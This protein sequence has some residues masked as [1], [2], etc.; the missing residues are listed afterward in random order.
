[1]RKLILQCGLA[2]GD[3]VMLTA[4][5]R[6]MHHHY[7]G[8][9]L[10]DVRTSCPEI[11]ENNPHI[12]PLEDGD[13]E[14]ER[15]ECS[16]SLIDQADRVPY[17][18]LHGFIDFFNERFR[19]SIRPTAFRGDI[20]LS[21]QDK[22][23]YSQVREVTRRDIPFWI[24]AAGGKFDITIKWWESRRYQEVVHRLAG[25][26][27]FVQ[28]GELGHHHP[29]LDG[30][31]DLR[32]QTNLRELIR[33]VYHSE[34]VVCPTTALMHLAAAVESKHGWTRRRPCVVIAGGREPTHW[35]QYPGHHYLHTIGALPCCANGGC[36][37]DRT[38]RLRDGE[39]QDKPENLCA[40]VVGKLPK[41]LDLITA[42]DVVRRIESYFSGGA[43]AY[44]TSSQ[45]KAAK[46]GIAATQRNRYDDQPLNL[47]SAG[48]AFDEAAG[49]AIGPVDGEGKG[50]VI[51][52]GGVRYFTNAWVCINM[53]RRLGCQLPVEVWHLGKREMTEKMRRLLAKLNV[54]TIDAFQVRRRKPARRLNGWELKV[55]AIIHSRFREVLFLDADNVPVANPEFLFDCEEFRSA[56]AI[57]WP[58]FKQTH[59]NDDLEIWRS[60]GL[61][62]PSEPEFESGQI[63][64]D[65]AR[66]SRALQLCLWLNEHSDFYYRH[67]YG[68]KE[69][70]HLAFQK[71]HKSYHLIKHPVLA[72]DRTMCQHDPQG[73][74]LFQ[75]RNFAK[76]DLVRNPHI[77]GFWMESECLGYLAELKKDWDGGVSDYSPP[78]PPARWPRTEPRLI[79]AISAAT[80]EEAE[81]TQANLAATDWHTVP[82]ASWVAPETARLRWLLENA[83]D[84]PADYILL[85]EGELV[86]NRHIRH[87]LLRWQPIRRRQAGVASVYNPQIQ[88][89]ACDF[90]NNTRLVSK[91]DKL[92]NEA[93]V[94]SAAAARIILEG[95]KRTRVSGYPTVPKVAARLGQPVMLH[96]PSLVQRAFKGPNGDISM[97]FDFDPQWRAV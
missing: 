87:N 76:W 28:V 21:A 40:N 14:A 50:I 15:V 35:E 57:F 79:S 54:R 71:A 30:V 27:Q 61:R 97:A 6:D 49:L 66:C 59:Q 89:N 29:R 53:L 12:T 62:R 92:G 74:R 25:K 22:A 3:I 56:G 8:H 44:L 41:C 60:C 82:V 86:F 93:I 46:R 20:H 55:Y 36:W 11:W 63:L 17:H 32:G 78:R 52:A 84:H 4:A 26:V 94:L 95:L 88:E 10:T 81:Q 7:P 5:V 96:A 38:F 75:H 47:S 69:T 72:L 43:L 19:L 68:D 13:P 85:L 90:V 67:I 58:D 33:L 18:C 37:K 70:F 42:E 9:F 23:W 45:R 77:K 73:R 48:L 1:M 64:V 91:P 24:I 51:C 2:V 31:I 34:G 16:Y 39:P 83:L 65:K 80:C